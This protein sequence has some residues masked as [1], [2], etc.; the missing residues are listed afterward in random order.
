ME[1]RKPGRPRKTTVAAPLKSAAPVTPQNAE[2]ALADDIG[3]FYA[4]PLGFARYAYPWGE[5]GMLEKETGLDTWQEDV[6][7]EIGEGV[8]RFLHAE[9]HGFVIDGK[10]VDTSIKIAVASGNGIGKSCLISII[11]QWFMSTRP[12]AQVVVMAN[13]LPQLSNKTWRELAKWHKLLINKDWFNWTATRFYSKEHPETWFAAATPWSEEHPEAVSGTHERDVLMIMDEASG[14]SDVIWEYIDPAM[15]TPGAMWIA[16]GNPTRNNGRFFEC[17]GRFKHRWITR[18]I[19]SR[20]CKKADKSTIQNW[21]EDY[22][23]D[24]DYVRVR[25]KG[26]FPRASDQQFIGQDIVDKCVKYEANGWENQPKLMGVDVARYG[27]DQSVILVRQGRKIPYIK[28]Y[29]EMDVMKL[30]ALVVEA[31]NE[32]KPDAIFIDAV[33]LGA[34][35]VDRVRQ[36]GVSCIEVN[37]GNSAD[38]PKYRNKRAEMWAEMRNW[39]KN[40]AE[41]PDDKELLADLTG[42]EYG[43]TDTQKLQLERKKD[44]KKRGLSSPDAADALALTFAYPVGGNFTDESLEPEVFADT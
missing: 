35:V 9:K 20:T 18:Q 40:G 3:R 13:T 25:V 22:G 43:Y 42:P 19:D 5:P 38:H 7:R 37:A 44:M 32:E 30:S 36:L 4:D 14:I 8:K 31:A 28:R 2:S 16:F 12:H 41:L 17:F 34:G 29:R 26:Q 15:T 6:L 10:P 39:L 24:S 23:E 11:N 21:V 1:K 33:G 27:D